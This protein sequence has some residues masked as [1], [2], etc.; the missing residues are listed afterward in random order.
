MVHFLDP[1][2]IL[3]FACWAPSEHYPPGDPHPRRIPGGLVGW[4]VGWFVCGRGGAK[5]KNRIFPKGALIAEK[6]AFST[7]LLG[8]PKKK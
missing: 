8:K 3:L 2:G 1:H 7:F 4:W 5:T 6:I